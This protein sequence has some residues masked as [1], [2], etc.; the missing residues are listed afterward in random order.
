MTISGEASGRRYA[1]ET[2]PADVLEV[3]LSVQRGLNPQRVKAL[4]A[5]FDES[6]LGVFT[7]SARQS[8][9]LGGAGNTTGQKIRY[10]VLDGQTRLAAL[11]LFTGTDKTKMPV[12]CQVY[13]G[14]TR[15]EEADLFLSHNNRAA[16]RA[17]DKFRI[18]L[19]AGEPGALRLNNIVTR[20]GFETGVNPPK[21]RRFTAVA[22]AL[23]IM[24]LSD[25]EDALDRAF[26]LIVR[27][28]G[29]RANATSAEAIDGLGMLFHRHGVAVDVPGFAR[30]LA[31]KDSPQNFKANVMALR[32]AMRLSRTEAS[33]A[34]ALQVYNSGRRSM[35]LEPRGPRS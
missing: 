7:V 18:A 22:A 2:L 28:W 35:A 16:V 31:S 14:L 15:Q 30:K 25:G 29:H 5:D 27:T 23:K 1:M 3:D 9:D 20:H 10:I 4:A 12:V 32:G 6:A 34:Y 11:R 24:R 33:Y 19:V 17:V 8:L 13:Y 21:E 26:E